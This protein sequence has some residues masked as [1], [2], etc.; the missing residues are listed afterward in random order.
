MPIYQTFSERMQFIRQNTPVC[1]SMN[2]CAARTNACEQAPQK[3]MV[4]DTERRLNVLFDALN[5][6]TLSQSAV[7]GLNGIEQ[8]SCFSIQA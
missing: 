2:S 1:C 3:K 8:G 7:D 4:D 5:C 6:E